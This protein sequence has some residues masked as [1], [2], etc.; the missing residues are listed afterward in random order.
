MRTLLCAIVVVVASLA[1]RPVEAASCSITRMVGVAFGGYDPI[2]GYGVEAAGEIAFV[3]TGV[4]ENDA[5][6]VELGRGGTATNEH[7]E[8]SSGAWRLAYDLFLDAARTVVWGDGSA[9]TGRYGPVVPP[10]GEEV[11]ATVHGLIPGG[12]NV[13]V[14]T[15]ADTV[16]VTLTF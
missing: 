7:R 2:S 4:G 10:E 14:G 6:V 12:Q 5:V 16:V 3:C 13:G 8:L 1:F 15:Y 11:S 9:G